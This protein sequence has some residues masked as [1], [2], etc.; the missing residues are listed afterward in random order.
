MEPDPVDDVVAQWN[1]ERPGVDVSGMAV[2]G[3]ISRL[4]RLLRPHLNAVFAKH[5]LESWEFDVLATLVRT[6]EPNQLTPGELLESMLI[7]SGAMTNRIDRL[8]KRGFVRR[9]KSPTDGRQVLVS[10]TPKGRQK[11]DAALIDHTENELRM[12]AALDRK[13]QAELIELLRLVH[14]SITQHDQ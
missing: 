11:V 4:E 5:D 8:E 3:R 10:L 12:L 14:H 6:G 9:I 1:R 7:T 13:Q 2:I